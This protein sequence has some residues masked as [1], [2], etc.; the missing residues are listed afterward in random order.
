M[1]LKKLMPAMSMGTQCALVDARAQGVAFLRST[2]LHRLSGMLHRCAA[3]HFNLHIS[4]LHL[5]GFCFQPAMLLPAAAGTS[6]AGDSVHVQDSPSR[7][8]VWCVCVFV[9]AEADGQC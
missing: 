7:A 3:L 4:H 5:A 8:P 1:K 2:V 6:T 9:A